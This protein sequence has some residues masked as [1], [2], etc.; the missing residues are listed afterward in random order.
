MR[1]S[2][3]ERPSRPR[4]PPAR[5][6]S[7]GRCL[8]GS[9][10]PSREGGRGSSSWSPTRAA[11]RTSSSICSMSSSACFRASSSEQPAT[12]AAPTARAKR[13][14]HGQSLSA[15]PH[16]LIVR[17]SG[18]SRPG[19]RHLDRAPDGGR[20]RL[21]RG[22]RRA[23]GR[24]RRDRAATPRSPS[25]WRR[26]SPPST[27]PAAGTESTGS[28][29]ASGQAPSP[30]FESGSRRHVRSRRRATCRVVGVSSLRALAEG[31]R[32]GG[33]LRSWRCSTRSARSRLRPSTARRAKS[34]G[35]PGWA[36]R[37]SLP[38]A[39]PSCLKRPLAVGD[40]AVRFRAELEASG[41]RIPPDADPRH[42]L[43]ARHVCRLAGDAAAEPL[44]E[45]KPTYLRR[46]D[47]ELWRERDRGSTSS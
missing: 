31:A 24:A 36:R 33:R 29:W 40:G 2:R 28:R 39:S 6:P 16:R 45:I 44:A 22:P 3:R 38:I 25:A 46:P 4:S 17:S 37:P 23:G 47:A 10:R 32:D 30:G 42:R 12:P 15:T 19:S 20:H 21:G 41:A 35:S 11:S 27:R 7:P 14:S 9:A 8:P 1:L 18:A 5:P 43:Y 34:A 26:S 13:R